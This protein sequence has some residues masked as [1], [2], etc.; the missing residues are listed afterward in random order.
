MTDSSKEKCDFDPKQYQGAAM[1]M[2]HCPYCCEMVIAGMPHPDYQTLEDGREI[3]TID[4]EDC[5]E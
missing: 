2:F 4:R 1:G 5:H 3:G